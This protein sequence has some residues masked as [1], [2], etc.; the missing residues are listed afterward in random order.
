MEIGFSW[1][2]WKRQDYPDTSQVV[3]SDMGTPK[4]DFNIYDALREELE[5]LGIPS[6]EIAYVH[7]ATTEKK[8]E[9]LFKDV[10][11][12]KIRVI[13]GSTPKLGIGT[14]IQER[15]IAAHHLS[16]PWKP[17]EITQRE[18][19]IIRNFNSCAEV[20]IFRYITSDSFDSFSW[21]I[22]ENKQKFISSFLSGASNVRDADDIEAILNYA[23]IKA[24]FVV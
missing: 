11:E 7:D 24:A 21:Q 13:I 23:E 4:Y 8:R 6:H 12:G 20:F 22:L 9:K 19:R 3:F 5:L 1:E 16:I 14:N 18:G 15:L 17:A 2:K 10:N